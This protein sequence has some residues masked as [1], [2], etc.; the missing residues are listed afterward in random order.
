M[1]SLSIRLASP[2][3]VAG[4]HGPGNR[5]S[6][7]R[8]ALIAVGM[9]YVAT[10][11]ALWERQGHFIFEPSET[12]QNSPRDYSFA[13]EDVAIPISGSHDANELLDG[14]WIPSSTGSTRTVLYLHGNEGNVSTYVERLDGLRKLGYSVFVIDY[15]GYGRSGGGFPT[16]TGVYE[17][18]QAAWNY[19]VGTR[20]IAPSNVLIYGHSLGG[21]IAIELAT[22]HPEALGLVVESSFTSISDMAAL[23]PRYAI[24]PVSL[25]LDQR[26][27][28]I[29]KVG[30][31]GLP[32]MYVH[33]TQDEVVPFAMGRKLFAATPSAVGLVSVAGGGHDD[34]ALKGGSR[35]LAAVDDFVRQAPLGVR[36]AS[37]PDSIH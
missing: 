16:E 25:L 20:R 30:S 13:V 23:D 17:D 1:S 27:D 21:A 7:I 4:R 24:L 19:L 14:W 6:W 22:H 3:K 8:A 26:F 15:R 32:V 9:G 33:G 12:L 31:L 35:L 10:C 2:R 37:G 29:G 34:N 5:G 36:A 11:A 28:S 18:A